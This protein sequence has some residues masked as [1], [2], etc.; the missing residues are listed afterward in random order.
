TDH[1]D[2]RQQIYAGT[3]TTLQEVAAAKECSQARIETWSPANRT[4]PCHVSRE[5][6]RRYSSGGK[7]VGGQF[8]EERFN[9]HPA[10]HQQKMH[11]ARL[12]HTFAWDGPVG[13]M[14]AVEQQHF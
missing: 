12:R 10:L 5:I 1:A 14:V 8:G 7:E 11:V 4:Q 13:E 9:D 2:V 6:Q 3:D